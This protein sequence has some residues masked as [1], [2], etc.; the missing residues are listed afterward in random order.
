MKSIFELE[1]QRVIVRG[2]MK[3]GVEE[4]KVLHVREGAHAFIVTVAMDD[5]GFQTIIVDLIAVLPDPS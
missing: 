2:I 1:G 3:D 4:G 5:G